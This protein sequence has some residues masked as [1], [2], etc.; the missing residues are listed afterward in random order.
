[1]NKTKQM[2]T[3]VLA[4]II[5]GAG[6]FLLYNNNKDETGQDTIKTVETT[7]TAV[8]EKPKI[9]VSE[10]QKTV[11]YDGQTGKT[12]LEIL[13]KG[14]EVTMESSSFGDF[15]TGINDVVA[16]SSK[17]YWSFYVNGTY[18]SEGA[19]TYKTT[20]G[21]KIEWRLEEL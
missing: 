12:A 9:T 21:E 18:A 6:G 17:N 19:G 10:D 4:V 8:E 11:S 7:Q 1:M 5:L 20:D 14:T 2:V 15:V 16:D 3:A 13:Q